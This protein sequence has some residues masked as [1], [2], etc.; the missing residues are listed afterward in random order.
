MEVATHWK[1][2]IWRPVLDQTD[3]E[4]VVSNSGLGRQ[5]LILS[6]KLIFIICRY[7]KRCLNS[8]CIVLVSN[9]GTCGVGPL[10][11]LICSDTS[12]RLNSEICTALTYIIINIIPIGTYMVFWSQSETIDQAFNCEKGI[13]SEQVY[14]LYKCTQ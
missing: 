13:L 2:V 8:H 6:I 11:T 10:C 7:F 3:T 9:V 4:S 5:I 12:Y 1:N 14:S